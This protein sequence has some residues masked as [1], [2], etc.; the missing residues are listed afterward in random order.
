LGS[1]CIHSFFSASASAARDHRPSTARLRRRYCSRPRPP[2]SVF[3]DSSTLFQCY[4]DTFSRI[5]PSVICVSPLSASLSL[6]P[7]SSQ[8]APLTRTCELRTRPFSL[9]TQIRTYAQSFHPNRLCFENR[10]Q[11]FLSLAVHSVDDRTRHF[12]GIQC[13]AGPSRLHSRTLD[14]GSTN[15]VRVLYVE[16]SVHERSRTR[17]ENLTDT[18]LVLGPVWEYEPCGWMLVCG[19]AMYLRSFSMAE[20]YVK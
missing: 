5:F 15:E 11:T 17:A 13:M 10:H 6:A 16:A 4:A 14:C 1:F 20:C 3:S 2:I 12:T 18:Q 19:N 8:L 9:R 7:L